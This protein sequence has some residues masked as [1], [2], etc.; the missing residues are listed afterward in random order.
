MKTI[1]CDSRYFNAKDTLE[2]GQIFRFRPI[3]EWYF[4]NSGN[5]ACYLRTKDGKTEIKCEDDDVAYFENFFDLATDYA[6]INCRALKS[7]YPI[8]EKAAALASGVRILRQNSTEMLF[9]FLVSQ[10]NNIPRIK[11]I[12]ERLCVSAG[13]K[14]SSCGTEYFAFPSTERLKSEDIAFYK[15]MGLGYRADFFKGLADVICDERIDELKKLNGEELKKRLLTI[16]GIGDKVADCVRLFGFY[17]TDSFPVDVWIEKIYRED[18]CGKETKREKISREFSAA[19]GNDSGYFQQY[20][21]H[22]KRNIEG[23]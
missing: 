5:K 18:F 3:D 12:L 13:E 16:R 2:C 11:G 17:K 7:G 15:S 8:L 1:E 22:Y 4:V 14:M 20:L 9:S 19:F 6:A 10:N 21:F 23:R